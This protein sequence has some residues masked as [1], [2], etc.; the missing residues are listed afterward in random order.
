MNLE[1]LPFSFVA[2]AA[3]FF[4]PCVGAM[5]P[6]YVSAYLSHAG[7]LQ[8]SGWQRGKHGVALGAVVSA[9]FLT[10]FAAL[11]LLFGLIGSAIGRYVPWVAV[12]VGFFIILTGIVL[13]IKPSFSLSLGGSFGR[14]FHPKT[15]LGLWSFYGY[16]MAYAV[17]AAAC[18]LPIF[19]SVMTQT[20]V[21]GSMLA[22]VL[23]F[24]AYG[25]GMSLLMI[26]FSLALAYSKDAVYKIF[27]RITRVVQRISGVFMILAGGY[28]LYYLLIYG[29]YLDAFF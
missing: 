3:T 7:T 5:L 22:G 8:R 1:Y 20:F 26:L 27:P 21:G 28:V 10:S 24:L 29:R 12:L 23:N 9:G 17:C 25:W 15:G 2:G 4:S 11:G 6:A 19:L 14:W 13:L 18:T 16:G